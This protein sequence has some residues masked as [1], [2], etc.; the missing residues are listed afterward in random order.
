MY[1]DILTQISLSPNEAVVYE[2]LLKNGESAAG[3]IIKNTPLKR[4]VIYNALEELL[5][6]N[7]AAKKT[8]NKIAFFSPNHPDKLRE[9]VDGREKEIAKAKNSL[10]ANLPALV[11]DF[12]L[13]S[14]RP[15]IRYFEGIEGIKK[16]LWDSLTAKTTI[17]T[18]GDVEAVVK[19]IDKINQEYIAKREILGIKKQ[20]ILLDSPFAR[21]YLKD[22]HRGITDFKFLDSRRYTFSTIVEIYDNKV[23][24]VTLNDDIKIGVIIEDKNIFQFHK[25]LFEFTWRRAK[26][27]DQLEDFSKAQ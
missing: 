9:Y 12:N 18:Y 24:Y 21:D 5:K 3:Q 6:K 7:L 2:Y 13:V 10:E 23:S 16:V 22:Y 8:K 20:A 26:T 19:Y 1:K 11:S 25:S 17:R 27:F 15:G 14:G 4:G